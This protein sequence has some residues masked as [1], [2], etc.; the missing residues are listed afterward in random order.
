MKKLFNKLQKNN[1]TISF[2]E[3]MTAGYLSYSIAKN[4]GASNVLIGSIVAYNTNIKLN[5]LKV[6]Q[7]TINKYTVV[8]K[9]VADEMALNLQ[10]IITSDIYVSI[11]GNAGPTFEKNTN[12]LIFYSTIIFQNKTYNITH[13]FKT[14][15]RNKNIIQAKNIIA[16]QIIKIIENVCIN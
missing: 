1:L 16:S 2:A 8:S 6:K 10:Q 15:D 4:S 12:N 13:Q 7:E 3:S 9:E 14:N 11:T 5:I